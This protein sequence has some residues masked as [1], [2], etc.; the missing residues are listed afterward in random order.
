VRRLVRRALQGALVVLLAAAI[1]FLLVRLAPG[2]PLSI[3]LDHPGI[4]AATRDHWRAAWGLDR[5]APEQFLRWVLSAVRGD[6]GHSFSQQRSVASAIAAALPYSVVLMGAAIVASVLVGIMIGLAQ[7]RRARSGLDSALNAATLVGV[8]A[9]E[10]W[11]GMLLLAAFALAIPAFPLGWTPPLP[12]EGRSWIDTTRHL[13]LP[14]ATLTIWGAS[15]VA[16]HQRAAL[17]AAAPGE[18]VRAARARGVRESAL[19]WRHI[20]RT[21]LTPVIALVGLSLPALAGGAVFVERVFAWPG[22][23]SLAAAGVASRDAPLV[24]A[25]TFLG[26]VLVVVGSAL[27]D[28]LAHWLDPRGR[29]AN[30]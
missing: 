25:C 27:A 28:L 1:T 7:A 29:D 19:W 17:I 23:G 10:P 3:A 16:R 2:D 6:F 12:G 30:G 22:M 20:L 11:V 14:V 24:T 18:F 5:S 13:V 8:A 26:A 21:A 4:D 15:I 9:P